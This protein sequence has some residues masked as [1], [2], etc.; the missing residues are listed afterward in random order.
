MLAFISATGSTVPPVY[1][2]PRKKIKPAMYNDGPMGCIGLTHESGCM[3]G[4]NF[5]KSLQH[6]HGFVKCTKFDPVLMTLDNHCSHL[7][8]QAVSFA[9]ENGIFF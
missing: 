3:T 4:S 5:F 9:K 2:Y 1:I 6:F 8:Y 7:D